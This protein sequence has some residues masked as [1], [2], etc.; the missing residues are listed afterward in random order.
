MIERGK[1]WFS[2][3]EHR[4]LC[5][6][7]QVR[8]TTGNVKGWMEALW[9]K[10]DWLA[11]TRPLGNRLFDDRMNMED[12]SGRKLGNTTSR[13]R[14]LNKEICEGQI[15]S[16]QDHIIAEFICHPLL[17]FFTSFKLFLSFSFYYITHLVSRGIEYL[18]SML[19]PLI[20]RRSALIAPPH[21]AARL[22][23]ERIYFALKSAV[24]RWS[25]YKANGPKSMLISNEITLYEHRLTSHAVSDQDHLGLIVQFISVLD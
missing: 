19:S 15:S 24:C 21:G 11:R 22:I 12:L 25:Q 3:S 5:T 1:K 6:I 17:T 10:S 16:Q 14:E 4:P 9:W 13:A 23:I 18:T 20:I 8:Q 2:E 7:D